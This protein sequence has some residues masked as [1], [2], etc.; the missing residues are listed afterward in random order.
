MALMDKFMLSQAFVDQYIQ[1]CV[2]SKGD[3]EKTS[4]LAL[5]GMASLNIRKYRFILI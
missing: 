2:L 5:Y 1:E 3:E 4:I